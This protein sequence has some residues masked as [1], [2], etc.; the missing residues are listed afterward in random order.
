[1]DSDK[2]GFL[3]TTQLA[4]I[5]RLSDER[6]R[7]LVKESRVKPAKKEGRFLY[8]TLAA[9]G[10]YCDFIREQS[11]QKGPEEAEK[12][13]GDA[14]LRLKSAKAR[15]AELELEELEGKMHQAEDVETIFNDLVYAVKSAIMAFPGRCAVNWSKAKS[16]AKASQ[17]LE[18]E[19]RNVL[20]ELADYKY[21]PERMKNLARERMG[22]EQTD[23]DDE[24][25]E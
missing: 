25:D 4:Q 22:R 23:S 18:D 14:E 17:V 9:V 24:Q 20:N 19:T 10:D 13:K 8:F 12:A 2:S 1:M 5:L 16:A 15:K 7:Q 11:K 21:D 3:S 6:I